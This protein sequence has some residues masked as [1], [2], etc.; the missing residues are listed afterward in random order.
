MK[1]TQKREVTKKMLWHTLKAVFVALLIAA[2]TVWLST[3]PD[4]MMDELFGPVQ[5]GMVIAN[6]LMFGV[7][8]F[9]FMFFPLPYREQFR[10]RQIR[11]DRRIT[12]VV[13]YDPNYDP[14]RVTD[15]LRNND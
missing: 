5:T 11:R 1:L 9:L 8:T 7:I 10:R 15:T 4:S 14:R 13:P 3:R 12:R 2:F 6:A